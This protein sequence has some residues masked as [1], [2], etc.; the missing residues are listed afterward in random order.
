MATATTFAPTLAD[1]TANWL[2]S[3]K[4]VS[5]QLKAFGWVQTADTGQ[6]NWT[7]VTKPTAATAVAGVEVFHPADAITMSIYMPMWVK[8]RPLLTKSHCMK[9]S[10]WLI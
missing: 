2:L 6:I 4:A 7:T 3:V 8:F 10:V 5:D 9:V 1:T